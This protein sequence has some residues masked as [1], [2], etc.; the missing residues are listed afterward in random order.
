M[1]RWIG[2]GLLLTLMTLVVL[3]VWL[4]PDWPN[5][6]LLTQH[7]STDWE[8]LPSAQVPTRIQQLEALEAIQ[9]LTVALAHP[10]AEVSRAAAV[11]LTRSV[12]GWRRMPAEA[13]SDRAILLAS[14]L[15]QHVREMGPSA[16]SVAAQLAAELVMF[17]KR[18]KIADRG[19]VLLEC[20]EILR[21]AATHR[22][23][24]RERFAHTP[25]ADD[26]PRDPKAIRRTSYTSL[27]NPLDDQHAGAPGGHLPVSPM[28][29]PSLPPR[30]VNPPSLRPVPPARP[31]EPDDFELQRI[32]EPERIFP[33]RPRIL[34]AGDNSRSS[35]T[36][37]SKADDETMRRIPNR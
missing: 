10:R 21:I 19:I 16:Q 25:R 24:P 18:R 3:A 8:S 15:R 36:D 28:E 17:E 9:E 11:A 14:L 2:R 1:R 22:G 13:Q 12:E 34:D 5:R 32:V 6:N 23:S 7:F 35:S 33:A 31:G 20:D 29:V 4:V 26:A 37:Q 27:L 30:L